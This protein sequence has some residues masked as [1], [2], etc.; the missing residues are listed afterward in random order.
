MS[1]LLESPSGKSSIN[2]GS[3]YT[4]NSLAAREDLANLIANT[5]KR[6]TPFTSLAPKGKT[7]QSTY[8]EWL[9][10]DYDDPQSVGIRDGV[11]ITEGSAELKNPAPNRQRM[12]N[13]IQMFRRA[14]AIGNLAEDVSNIAGAR[15]EK[16][17]G[18]QKILV[19][20]KRDMEVAFTATNQDAQADDGSTKGYRTKSLGSFLSANGNAGATGAPTGTIVPSGFRIATAALEAT[21][22]TSNMTDGT[23]Q[24]ILKGI[25]DTTGETQ[26]YVGLMGSTLKRA[27]TDRLTGTDTSGSAD[28]ATQVRTFS[29]GLGE[30]IFKNTIS[31]FEGD[32]G[33]V[34]LVPTNF[35][36]SIDNGASDD[37]SGVGA[38]T[39]APTKGYFLNMDMV[40]LKYHSMPSVKPLPDQGGGPRYYCAAVAGL[41]VKSPQ[42]FGFMNL[43]S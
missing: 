2:Y 24:D 1:S 43:G 12:G 16:A 28:S 15:S 39:S 38:W 4:A 23:V 6:N 17:A 11:A 35:L 20:M 31:V 9:L 21:A 30:N 10:D 29:R 13:H 5:D 40:E 33:T 7:P 3:G 8:F 42:A 37:N 18:I 19:E 22:T 32:F 25:F 34:N 14:H 41:C 36:G 26:T 27:F